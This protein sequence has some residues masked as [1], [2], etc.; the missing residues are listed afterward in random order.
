MLSK[1]QACWKILLY[2]GPRW[3]TGWSASSVTRRVWVRV[4]SE[5]VTVYRPGVSH[6]HH[7]Y[8]IFVYSKALDDNT[9]SGLQKLKI[10]K[11]VIICQC[12]TCEV[13]NW[14]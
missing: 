10:I 3:P 2:G 4:S 5:P 7:H 9:A 14:S 8:H 12:T 6:H 13:R 11:L 1:L